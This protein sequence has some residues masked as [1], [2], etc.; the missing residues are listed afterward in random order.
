MYSL[1]PHLLKQNPLRWNRDSPGHPRMRQQGWGTA[2][3]QKRP[4]AWD[5]AWGT[6]I[7]CVCLRKLQLL[8]GT[9]EVWGSCESSLSNIVLPFS[10]CCRCQPGLC[11]TGAAALWAVSAQE[12]RSSL[13]RK[14]STLQHTAEHCKPPD[15]QWA[16]KA[17]TRTFLPKPPNCLN[18]LHSVNKAQQCSSKAR[19][20]FATGG[21]LC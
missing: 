10:R 7:V 20:E 16:V 18:N 15:R 9:E 6:G 12:R 5:A 3:C 8:L 21:F 11:L 4:E 2:R 17:C 1:G 13:V 19:D 14:K